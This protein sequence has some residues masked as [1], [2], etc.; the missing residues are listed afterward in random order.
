MALVRIGVLLRLP[1]V[2]HYPSPD[3]SL[4]AFVRSSWTY[5]EVP[6]EESE[7]S[8]DGAGLLDVVEHAPT[9]HVLQGISLVVEGG[10]L[11]WV[12]GRV[13]AG[14]TSLLLACL[15]EL[16]LTEGSLEVSPRAL[17]CPQTAAIVTGSIIDNIT[18]GMEVHIAL[19][20]SLTRSCLVVSAETALCYRTLRPWSMVLEQL[21]GSEVST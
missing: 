20:S 12:C 19:I 16:T 1:N 13:G 14:K 10:Q 9:E 18:W 21:L 4:L 7:E 15:G 6:G 8:K 2:T 5:A 3:K 11:V 17:Y